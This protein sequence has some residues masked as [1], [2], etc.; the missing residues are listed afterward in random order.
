MAS[1][2]RIASASAD[3]D[4][5]DLSGAGAKATGGRW[6]RKGVPMVYTSSSIA[7]AALE[8]IVHLGA[9]AFSLNRYVIEIKIP[10][11]EFAGRLVLKPPPP[12]AWDSIPESYKSK[13]FGSAWV[14]SA[15]HLVLDVPSAIVPWERNLLLNPVHPASKALKATNLGKFVYDLRLLARS[16]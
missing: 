13:D 14:A 7:L 1:V 16:G 11:D 15:S 5:M 2:Y 4:E 9:D 12:D 8:M 10:D 6:N 3:W